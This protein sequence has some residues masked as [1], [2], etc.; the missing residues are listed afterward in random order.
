MIKA[1]FTDEQ[2]KSL[3]DYQ[4]SGVFHDFTCGNCGNALHAS[5]DGWH[6]ST[7]GCDYA[8]DWAHSWM[9]DDNWRKMH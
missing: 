9:A 1:P 6:C 5:N 3:N 7:P 8:Q 4:S 2:V